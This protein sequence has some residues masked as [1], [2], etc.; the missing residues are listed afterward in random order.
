MFTGAIS[1]ETDLRHEARPLVRE[2]VVDNRLERLAQ[3]A[4]D[5]WWALDDGLEQV[6]AYHLLV[7]FVEVRRRSLC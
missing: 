2:V 1:T 5:Q 6:V 7:L 4:S 3:L